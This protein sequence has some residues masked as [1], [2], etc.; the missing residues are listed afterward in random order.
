MQGE[1]GLASESPLGAYP[2]RDGSAASSRTASDE[3]CLGVVDGRWHVTS[4]VSSIGPRG[5]AAALDPFSGAGGQSGA[6]NDC[7]SEQEPKSPFTALVSDWTNSSESNA[8]LP[9]DLEAT[10]QNARRSTE[11]RTRPGQPRSRRA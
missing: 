4:W 8:V 6:A 9:R 11:V 2:V 7:S 1:L 10:H 3:R 5:V